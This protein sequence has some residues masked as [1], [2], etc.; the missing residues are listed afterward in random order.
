[1]LQISMQGYT[2]RASA[3]REIHN[4]GWNASTTASLESWDDAGYVVSNSCTCK[5]VTTPVTKNPFPWGLN[6]FPN[7]SL[8]LFWCTEIYTRVPYIWWGLTLWPTSK[9]LPQTLRSC[10]GSGNPWANLL[11][12]T[13]SFLFPWVL[14]SAN[15]FVPLCFQDFPME[16]QI[17]G[18]N[19]MAAQWFALSLHKHDTSVFGQLGPYWPELGCSPWAC[20]GFQFP[21]PAQRRSD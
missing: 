21:H 6:S 17:P 10:R 12:D 20:V 5:P 8:L 7:K 4:H 11:I 15:T 9:P 2:S 19:G 14:W 18:S 1:M 16:N 13:V 3:W